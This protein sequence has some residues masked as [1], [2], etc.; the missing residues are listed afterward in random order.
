MTDLLGPAS[1]P[2]AATTRVS[3]YRSFGSQDTWF[4]DCST[5]ASAD[6]TAFQ[7][8]FFN[9]LLAQLRTTIRGNGQLISGSGPVVPENNSTDGMLLGAVQQLIARGQPN[10]AT[11]TGTADALVAAPSTVWPEYVQGARLYLVK[12]ATAGPNATTTP[13]VAVSGLA[14]VTIVRRDGT[15][16]AKGDLPAGA[17]LG[18][19][20]VGTYFRLVDL[21]ISDISGLISPPITYTSGTAQAGQTYV[22]DLNTQ[23]VFTLP[24]P[25]TITAGWNCTLRTKN[26]PSGY[27][28]SYA[29]IAAGGG[30]TALT[31][32]GSA[33][34]PFYLLGG[35]EGFKFYYDGTFFFASPTDPSPQNGVYRSYTGAGA[36]NGTGAYAYV[37][38][39][40]I[41]GS[42]LLFQYGT[43][44]ITVPVSGI[45]TI[46]MS[47]ALVG[48]TATFV[49]GSLLAGNS[50][51]PTITYAGV[52]GWASNAL[53]DSPQFSIQ[54]YLF[55]GTTVYGL[56]N[57]PTN[58]QLTYAGSQFS[59]FLLS[60]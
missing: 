26:S 19:E 14:A 36:V 17:V 44:Y 10:C 33:H 52:T 51:S 8:G 59:M 47:V 27:Q 20:Y 53:G 46:N 25:A 31:F 24:N 39:S 28:T 22:M 5:P 34:T 57:I 45:Y 3:E 23:Q 40:N 43:T 2:N 55:Q 49:Q 16:V 18:L 9:E 12:S 13:T 37:P 11:D 56:Y 30:S 6:G 32:R 1:A 58:M 35:G 50:N 41:S 21:A 15:P 7:A 42:P 60:R 29:Q 54:A 4:K 48:T 38:L